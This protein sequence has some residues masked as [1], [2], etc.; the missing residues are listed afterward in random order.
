M[1]N[2]DLA[3]WPKQYEERY[4]AFIDI[5][6]FSEKVLS[7]HPSIPTHVRRILA[8]IADD[9][10][11][12]AARLTG[13]DLRATHFSDC[14]VL[15]AKDLDEGLWAIILTCDAIQSNNWAYDVV[16][17]GGI[18]HGKVF[19]DDKG[20]FT[21]HPTMHPFIYGPAFLDA[22]KLESKIAVYPRIILS[23]YVVQK[24]RQSGTSASFSNYDSI[25]LAVSSCDNYT[26]I[27]P[28]SNNPLMQNAQGL[29]L[30][31]IGQ[32]IF[33]NLQHNKKR[34]DV[35]AKWSWLAL[36]YNEYVKKHPHS[37]QPIAI[38]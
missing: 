30:Q 36:R 27:N 16:F 1:T 2:T 8:S 9:I 4:V 31:A 3:E 22:Y 32:T 21:S 5:L 34:A 18:T 11:Q 6:G 38:P 33:S 19:H 10:H 13:A 24:A 15:S 12:T 7:P 17:R 14:F 37:A 20:N 26:Y 35:F 29:H 28:F 23:D 25:Y